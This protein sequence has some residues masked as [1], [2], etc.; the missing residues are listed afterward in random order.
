[1]MKRIALFFGSFN[2][3]HK[4]HIGIGQAVLD[5][6]KADEVYYV[7]SPRNPHKNKAVLF[8]E[9]KRWDMLSQALMPYNGLVAND[10]E[11]YMP[12]PSY[13]AQTLK[14][15]TTEHPENNY[16]MLM[17]ADSAIGL[18]AWQNADYI[19]QFP[20]LIYPRND[21]SLDAFPA[22]QQLKAPLLDVSA[23]RIRETKNIQQLKEWL[24]DGVKECLLVNQHL[25][26]I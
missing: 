7:L 10:T 16:I 22:H 9:E 23:S 5:Q 14:K 11:L 13:T 20:L 2:P 21:I 19:K 15:L 25:N 12:K 6:Q 24:P 8:P 4:G 1:M 3:I 18:E 26:D 17:G